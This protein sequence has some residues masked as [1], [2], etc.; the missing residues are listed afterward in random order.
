[1]K[2]LL[3]IFL[4]AFLLMPL[5]LHAQ[6]SIQWQK[7]FGGSKQDLPGS[8]I[9]TSDGGYIMT[10]STRSADGDVSSNHGGYDLWVVKLNADY[11][12][13]WQKTYGCSH[14]DEGGAIIESGGGYLIG[15]QTQSDD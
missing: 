5:I 2:R 10:G 11:S 12:I 14:D 15:G 6:P 1:M 9:P 7:C 8:I 13:K 3:Y 4:P